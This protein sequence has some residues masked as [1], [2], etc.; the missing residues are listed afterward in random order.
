MKLSQSVSR[1]RRQAKELARERNI[2]LHQALNA[3]AQQQGYAQWSL[4]V[5]HNPALSPAQQFFQKLHPGD[6]ALIAGRRNQGKTLFALEAIITAARASRACKIYS[7]E[8]TPTAL[9][10]Q[11]DALNAPDT[12]SLHCT[13]DISGQTIATDLANTN[14]PAFVLIDY[15]Q[16]LDHDRSK[17]DLATQLDQLKAAAQSHGAIICL[18]SQID[19]GFDES[20]KPFPDL[21]DLRLPNP[22][23]THLFALAA[24]LNK[25]SVTIRPLQTTQPPAQHGDQNSPPPPH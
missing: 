24:F 16:A 22:I 8:V 1:L 9:K 10:T 19:R 25:G 6:L 12:I 13:D 11:L 23:D 18:I 20:E 14:E 15:M 2:A 17:P 3:V 21:A 7:F 5:E 4:L